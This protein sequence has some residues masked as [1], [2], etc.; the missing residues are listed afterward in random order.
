MKCELCWLKYSSY[1]PF[2]RGEYICFIR[3]E[4]LKEREK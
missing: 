4:L 2:C 1:C 3:L